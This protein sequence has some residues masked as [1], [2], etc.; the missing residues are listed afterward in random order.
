M[1]HMESFKRPPQT[2]AHGCSGGLGNM[3][4]QDERCMRGFFH[5]PWGALAR[6]MW[7][8]PVI[9]ARRWSRM[10]QKYNN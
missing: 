1:T 10:L 2:S 7:L 3:T 6:S 8:M 4:V 5:V 9:R